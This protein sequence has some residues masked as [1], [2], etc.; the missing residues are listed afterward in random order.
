MLL[1][2]K[3]HL[4]NAATDDVHTTLLHLAA[5]NK[6]PAI[7]QLLLSLGAQPSW[8]NE[9]GLSPLHVA[10]IWG[11]EAAVKLLLESGADPVVVDEE[12]KTPLDHAGSEC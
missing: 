9:E 8:Q 6:K 2:S 3:P 4:V 1:S 12:D 10:A 11:N 5:A 7:L